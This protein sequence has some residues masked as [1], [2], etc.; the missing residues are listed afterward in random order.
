[1]TITVFNTLTR[2]KEPFV[3]LDGTRVDM[4]VCGPTVYNDAHM[5]HARTYLAFDV[6]ARYL[7]HRGYCV[8]YL[9]NITDIDDKIINRAMREGGKP[10]E[11]AEYYFSR[12]LEDMT[13]LGIDSVTH[14][15]K[16]T[17]FVDRIEGQIQ[18]LMEKDIAYQSGKDVYFHIPAFTDFGKLSRQ[19]LDE[20]R[21]G[22]RDLAGEVKRDP[23]DFA[24]WK[25]YKEGE[26]FWPSVFGDGRPGW[27]IED[28]AISIRYFGDQYD[29]H[30]GAKDL[31]FPHHEAE[32]A[33]AESVTDRKPFVKYW[34]HTGFLNVSGEKMSKSLGNFFTVREVLERYTPDVLRLFLLRTHYRSPIDYGETLLEEAASNYKRLHNALE[35]LSGKP[36]IGMAQVPEGESGVPYSQPDRVWDEDDLPLVEK[37]RVLDEEYHSA[38]DDDF[39]TRKALDAFLSF[40]KDLRSRIDSA[41]VEACEYALR[42]F[43][44]LASVLGFMDLGPR[45]YQTLEM[46]GPGISGGSDDSG[47]DVDG[48]MQVLIALRAEARARKDWAT[49]DMIR[50]RLAELGVVI[51]DTTD[52]SSWKVA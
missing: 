16:A 48:P 23:A 6:V 50:D 21:A 43:G 4:F 36:G 33:I 30:G 49:A 27:H 46:S 13:R 29:I 20:T 34:L 40:V 24:L 22:S 25:G 11:L 12:F 52:G 15:A 14:Y 3:P 5:G 41:S 28:T 39:D 44:E 26:P 19:K 9:M 38:M 47:V 32:I 51:E 7:R 37:V 17:E 42:T 8:F 10:D 1:M 31:I 2:E 18:A 35:W 45:M